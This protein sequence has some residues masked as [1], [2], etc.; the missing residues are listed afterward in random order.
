MAV[1]FAKYK[2]I[3]DIQNF[4]KK[5]WRSSILDKN[6]EFF[7]W[8]YSRKRLKSNNINFV[9]D[10][11]EDSKNI[12][13]CLGIIENKNFSDENIISNTVW[14]TNWKSKE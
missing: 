10:I 1:R 2:E 7:I 4:L 3:V 11:D 8:S 13:A 12:K 14:L 9:V 6:K 5:N